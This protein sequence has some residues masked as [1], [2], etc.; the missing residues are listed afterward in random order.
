MA[1]LVEAGWAKLRWVGVG[2]GKAGPGTTGSD[3]VG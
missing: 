3:T 1:G 2:S